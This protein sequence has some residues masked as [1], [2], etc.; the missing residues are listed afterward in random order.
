MPPRQASPDEPSGVRAAVGQRSAVPAQD[1]RRR[2]ISLV[3]A[4][5]DTQHKRRARKLS[6]A[7][8]VEA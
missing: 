1:N 6:Q 8:V 2:Q 7:P 3:A 5:Q 4:V